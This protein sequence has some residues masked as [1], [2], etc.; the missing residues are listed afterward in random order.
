MSTRARASLWLPT[1]FALALPV[2]LG[3]GLACSKDSSS[4]EDDKASSK[5]AKKSEGDEPATKKQPKSKPDD[6]EPA[7]PKLAC[8]PGK[9]ESCACLGGAQGVQICKD[10]GSGLGKCECPEVEESDLPTPE[11]AEAPKPIATAKPA[12]KVHPDCGEGQSET[13]CTLADRRHGWCKRGQCVDLCGRGKT[14]VALNAGCWP[15]CSKSCANCQE[16]GCI[17]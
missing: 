6:D 8:T 15:P 14:Y 11:P 3:S 10:D 16:G 13:P 1:L 7:A 2:V 9:Q 4:S 17:D 12:P 5:K